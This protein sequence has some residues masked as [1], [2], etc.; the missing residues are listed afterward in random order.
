MPLTRSSSG[1][2]FGVALLVLAGIGVIGYRNTTALDRHFDWVEHTYDTRAELQQLNASLLAV[3]TSRRGFSITGDEAEL[4][5]FEE[6]VTSG[7]ASVTKLRALTADNPSQQTRL[8]EL[9]RLVNARTEK[10]ATLVAA[11][12]NVLDPA[13]EQ[14]ATRQ[15]TLQSAAIQRAIGA[16]DA[17]ESLLLVRRAGDM[18]RGNRQ[19][20]LA[21]ALGT[22]VGFGILIAVFQVLRREIAA[23]ARG[24]ARL[25]EWGRIF[26]HAGWGIGTAS[27]DGGALTLVNPAFT[28]MHGLQGDEQELKGRALVDLVVPAHR[29]A[30]VD[31]LAR[32][33]ATGHSAIE[34]SHVAPGG[35]KRAVAV[36]ISRLDGDDIS[37]ASLVIN[38]QDITERQEAERDRDRFFELSIDLIAV[39]SV[40]GSFLRVNPSFESVLGYSASELTSRPF[41]DFVHPDDVDLTNRESARLATGERTKCFENRYRCKDGSYRWLQWTV[42]P[43]LENHLLFAVARDTTASKAAS[44]EIAA[45][46]VQLEQRIQAVT[47]VNEELETFSYS[48]S[49]DLRSPLRGIDGF[50]QA[51][52]ED[53][54]PVLDATAVGYL[55][56][57]RTATQR[58]GNLID[59]LLKL[60]KITRANLQ[61]QPTDVS[62][63]ARSIVTSLRD[64]EPTRNVT[65]DVADDL[66]ASADPQLLEIALENL[67]GNAWKFTSKVEHPHIEVGAYET[68]DGERGFFVKDN[69]AGFDMI[70][71]AKLFGAFQRLHPASEFSGTGIGLAT[72]RRIVTRHDGR[73]WADSRAGEG[74]TFFITL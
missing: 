44:A 21:T 29:E 46:N 6:G 53:Y 45:L 55:G 22:I 14:T 62:A 41:T 58:M 15:G 24:A 10:L 1:A 9:D 18:R 60:S 23:R 43:D 25:R 31:A 70:Y 32:A 59:D 16:M 2:A 56:R 63:L 40:D 37:P 52:L 4:E 68:A 65:I 27:I 50:S 64:A 5:R 3:E 34:S 7:R 38:V 13:A 20:T 66:R 28:A 42:A 61:R 30:T 69:G 33:R 39:A 49:H 74:A 36:D 26:E 8:D 35:R 12:R 19:T 72:V 57:I 48:V 17:E 73:V 51:L 71:A 54:G 11:R 47:V 67:L